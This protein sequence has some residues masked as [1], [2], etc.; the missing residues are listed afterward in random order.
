[1]PED[2]VRPCSRRTGGTTRGAGSSRP[3]NCSSPRTVRRE[4]DAEGREQDAEGRE[5]GAEGR[6]K[7]V[8]RLGAAVGGSRCWGIVRG[9]PASFVG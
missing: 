9:Q 1:M 2:W 6:A 8:K 5:Q 3:V 7:Q 4:Q